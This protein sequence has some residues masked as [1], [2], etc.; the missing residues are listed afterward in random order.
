MSEAAESTSSAAGT[1]PDPLTR[2]PLGRTGLS[3]TPLSIGCAP[4]GDMPETFGYS[5]PEDRARDLLLAAFAGP[6]NLLDTAAAY[7]DGESERRIGLALRE[8]G[9]LPEGFVVAT[10]A[11]RDLVTRDFSGDQAKRSIERSLRLLGLDRLQLVHLHDPEHSTSTFA[12]I[13]APGGPVDVLLRYREQGVIDHVGIAGG[14]IDDL[15]RYV[16]TGSFETVLTHNR[17]TLLHRGARPLFAVADRLG[18]AV[19]N[20]APYAS[21]LLATGSGTPARYVYQD[22]P[23][24]VIDRLQEIEKRCA[25]YGVPLAAAALQFS[26]RHPLVSSTIVGI[27]RAERL[28]D[29]LE[30]AA[31]HIPPGLWAE[32]EPLSTSEGDP[33]ADTEATLRA[34]GVHRPRPDSESTH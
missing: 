10:K 9:G 12:E 27:S 16:E 22:P 26:L 33:Q 29:T 31:L 6:I 7:G 3:V 15:I 20:G 14:P 25:A 28:T 18:V 30:L 11:D 21:G 5:V 32:L 4:L 8:L 13:M 17:Y 2:R 34:A 23:A 1:R 24:D 19:L